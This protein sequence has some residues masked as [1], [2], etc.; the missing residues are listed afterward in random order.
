V[1]VPKILDVVKIPVLASGGIGDARGYA[2]ALALGAEG[3]EM[4]TRFVATQ[5]CIAHA[6]YKQA[7]L[8]AKET[9][10]VIIERSIGKPARVLQGEWASKVAAV[11]AATPPPTIEELL[12]L[13]AGER[14]RRAALEGKLDEG[15]LWAGQV[16]GLIHD[17][18]TVRELLDR[19]TS[20]AE[21]IIRGLSAKLRP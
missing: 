18:P 9:D 7:L 3:I 12:P 8:D 5:E 13:I 19:F 21:E 14:N 1:L 4:G 11:E 16:S 17:I 2:A 6:N 20:G 10:T 15:F